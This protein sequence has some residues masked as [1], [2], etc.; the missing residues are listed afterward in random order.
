MAKKMSQIPPGDQRNRGTELV[1]RM[2]LKCVGEG[3][4]EISK[5]V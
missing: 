2:G 5:N 1:H 3:G 4:G